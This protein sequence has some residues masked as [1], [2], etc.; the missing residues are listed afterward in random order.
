M[1]RN[2]V[3]DFS[4]NQH[5]GNDI[6]AQYM[7]VSPAWDS[8]ITQYLILDAHYHSSYLTQHWALSQLQLDSFVAWLVILQELLLAIY[9]MASH[10][11]FHLDCNYYMRPEMHEKHK[12]QA[13]LVQ[14][15]AWPIYI[16]GKHSFHPIR[17]IR[18]THDWNYVI[19]SD[20]LFY[21]CYDC[22]PWWRLQA[23][24][25]AVCTL[26]KPGI[27]NDTTIDVRA[28]QYPWYPCP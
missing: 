14:W 5:Q 20:S 1:V 7:P 17:C 18:P 8:A 9:P 11:V 22:I 23:S 4:Y 2:K 13:I 19:V 26:S 12:L 24:F 21:L 10:D 25:V 15:T 28:L 3:H 16:W 6:I 27:L